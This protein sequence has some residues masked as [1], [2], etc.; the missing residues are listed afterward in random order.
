MVQEHRGLFFLR[1]KSSRY[2]LRSKTK[3]H[4]YNT[5]DQGWS[6]LRAKESLQG[7]MD[8]FIYLPR[9]Y[10]LKQTHADILIRCSSTHTYSLTEMTIS[11][12]HR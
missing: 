3:S 9:K 1:L 5:Y 12:F 7:G 8:K 4:F 10:I 6:Q 11:S 2:K